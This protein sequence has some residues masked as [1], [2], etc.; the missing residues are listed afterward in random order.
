MAEATK[1]TLEEIIALPMG[2]TP[3][4]EQNQDAYRHIKNWTDYVSG[5][6]GGGEPGFGAPIDVR[7]YVQDTS[8]SSTNYSGVTRPA[9]QPGDILQ[10]GHFLFLDAENGN[11][12]PCTLDIGLD[13][14]PI[15]IKQFGQPDPNK[16]QYGKLDCE[17]GT[18][19]G[20]TL[21]VYDG[22]HWVCD[23]SAARGAKGDDGD[24]GDPGVGLYFLGSLPSESDLPNPYDGNVGDAYIIGD[25]G[26]IWVYT[27]RDGWYNLG[28]F[29]EIIP[30]Y[31]LTQNFLKDLSDVT[32]DVPG[33]HDMLTWKD[34][35]WRGNKLTT[36]NISEEFKN[37]IINSIEDELPPYNVAN[38]GQVLEVED[39]N[40]S[41][42]LKWS[43]PFTGGNPYEW[44]TVSDGLIDGFESQKDYVV[45]YKESTRM[46]IEIPQASKLGV[47]ELTNT[48]ISTGFYQLTLGD[49]DVG[50]TLVVVV[51]GPIEMG[52]LFN[53][54]GASTLAPDG[55][56]PN[57]EANENSIYVL[58]RSPMGVFVN[59]TQGFSTV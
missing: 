39:D 27:E 29:P 53:V 26:D 13:A 6:A 42:I 25:T 49:F 30:P 45:T 8:G 31:D 41:A 19:Y 15:E 14:G 47:I 22:E 34:G 51:H 38:D 2:T 32:E 16:D 18:V 17:P 36:E 12:G 59:V 48:D 4:Y 57:A 33:E 7:W 40:G 11:T 44:G 43:D 55:A 54:E 37:D 21:M 10:K 50:H 46:V 35:S 23:R 1:Y 28:H 24:K 52:M 3:W 20:P 56:I 58:T 5:L 9:V